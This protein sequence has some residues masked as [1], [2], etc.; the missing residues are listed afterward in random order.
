M[1]APNEAV[2]HVAAGDLP[3]DLESVFGAQYDRIAR[4]IARVIRDPGRAEELAVEVFLKWSRH[5]SAH[6][7]SAA[8]WLYRTAARMAL[9][10]L[11]RD[12]RRNKFEKWMFAGSKPPTPAELHAAKEEQEK[13]RTVLAHLSPRDA[14]LLLL[15]SQGLD[16]NQLA[17]ALDLNPA[18][19]GTLLA[20]A[21]KT[22]R[23]E[24]VKKYGDA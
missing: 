7:E 5:P 22:F 13:V 18:S 4:V 1:T 15:R 16:Y 6:G 2:A 19:I 21:Q 8:G 24:Y 12:A 14:E 17:Q 20:R 11:R 3:S 23:K 9:D 10:E